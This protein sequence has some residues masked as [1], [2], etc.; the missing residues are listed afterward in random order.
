MAPVSEDISLYVGKKYGNLTITRA[1]R[2]N[3]LIFFDVICDCGNELNH[4]TKLSFLN[5]KNLYCKECSVSKRMIID[6]NDYIGK[7]YNKLTIK[8]IY[9][10][11]RRNYNQYQIYVDCI[12]E[13]G[14]ERKHV[15]LD[16]LCN[17]TV[18]SCKK[19]AKSISK[20]EMFIANVLSKNQIEFEF[21]KRYYDCRDIFELP[22]DFY[23]PNF[24]I[25]IEYDGRQH[26][27]NNHYHS[28]NDED[29]YTL[30]KHDKMKTEYAKNHGIK[31]IRFN[32]KQTSKQIE[33]ELLLIIGD[34]SRKKLSA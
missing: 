3:K 10:E 27:E 21:Q 26:Y 34:E 33:K 4:I 1:Y 11:K 28:G 13:C 30:I 18:Y 29:F 22:F 17:G 14:T 2:E 24:N 8:N 23:L 5:R 20:M 6:I 15:Q 25:L 31:L 32:Y 16:K 7:K 9:R 19:C 12:C